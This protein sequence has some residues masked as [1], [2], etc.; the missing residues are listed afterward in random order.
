M[1]LYVDTLTNWM[2]ILFL[3]KL[4]LLGGWPYI[5]YL[6]TVQV[7]LVTPVSLSCDGGCTAKH[8]TFKPNRC[9]RSRPRFRCRMRRPA[10]HRPG[11]PLSLS[12]DV[13][14][15][16][17]LHWSSLSEWPSGRECGWVLTR[18]WTATNIRTLRCF[19]CQSAQLGD[20]IGATSSPWV[21]LDS[22]FKWPSSSRKEWKLVWISTAACLPCLRYYYV[23]G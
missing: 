8:L 7:S 4:T 15:F 19:E 13:R 18:G 2:S 10:F 6:W 9:C 22:S 1:T 14:L 16:I 17:F 5:R 20:C 21:H 3:E 11:P 12:W 23:C